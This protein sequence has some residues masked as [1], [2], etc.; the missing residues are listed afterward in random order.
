MSLKQNG[1]QTLVL[2]KVV[3]FDSSLQVTEVGFGRSRRWATAHR[4]VAGRLL[5]LLI[6][7]VLSVTQILQKARTGEA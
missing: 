1:I 5:M 4:C 7:T 3:Y 2:A 6:V